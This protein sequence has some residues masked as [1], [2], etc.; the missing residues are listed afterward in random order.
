[1][2]YF[3]LFI[4]I[5]LA[6]CEK[7]N[8]TYFDQSP[9]LQ[10]ALADFEIMDGFNIEIVAAEPLISDPVAMEIDENGD[11]WVAE[12]PGYPLDLTKTGKIKKLI[13]TD[14]DGLPDKSEVFADSLTLP[15]GLMKWEDGLLVADAP[16]VTF[17]ADKDNDGKADVK[18]A[19]LT[20]FSLSNPQ[21]N[22]NTPKF[23]IDNWIYVAHSGAINSFAYEHVFSD[24]GSEIRFP[25]EPNSPKL[26][27][28]ADGRNVRFKPKS[29]ELETLSGESQYGHTTDEWG[30][31]FYTDNANHLF[32]EVMDA[33]YV[34]ANPNLAIEEAME[35][36]SDHG[37]A[38]KVFPITQNPNHQLLTDVGQ[39]TSSCGITW[40]DGGAFGSNFENTTLVGEP[41]HNL[42]HID[43]IET[44]GATFS[45][46]RVLENK[47]FLASKDP[48]FRPVFFYVG[49]DG[50]LYVVDYYRQIVEH[51]EWMS[52]EVNESGALYE[53]TK[54][55]RIYRITPKDGLK[56]DW[57]SALNLGEN[58]TEEL[59]KLLS[60]KNGWYR[61]TAQRLLFQRG[62]HTAA[63]FLHKIINEENEKAKIPALW[64]LHD[65][66]E[67]TS[68]D[69]ES[70]LAAKESGVRENALQL[71]DRV[72][73]NPDFQTE[74]LKAAILKTANDP[75]ER[76]RFQWLCSSAFF[77]F[78]EVKELKS[79]ILKNDVEDKWVGIAAIASSAGSEEILFQNA[80]RDFGTKPS[81]NKS[82]FFAHLAAT[83][84]KKDGANLIT[85][86]LDAKGDNNSWWQAA[87]LSG[88][89]SMQAY[90]SPKTLKNLEQELLLSTFLASQ[91]QELRK[92]I[93]RTFDVSKVSNTLNTA[94][95]YVK[96]KENSNIDFQID[97]MS[98][99]STLGEPKIKAK[100]LENILTGEN[101]KLQL[102]SIK[103]LSNTLSSPE[104]A[105][106]N[107]KYADLT[108]SSKK[109]W[110]AYLLNN[111]NKVSELIK[112]V[113]LGN[114]A[115]ADIEWP[116]IV[117]LMNYYDTNI[118]DYAREVF[119]IN[120]DR[121]AV[122]QNYLPAADMKGNAEN[123]KK[124]FTQN[125]A[126]CHQIDG[127]DGTAFG[128]DLATLKSRNK[129]SI[130][131]EIINPNNSIADKYGQWN[132]ETNDGN[133]LTGIIVSESENSLSLKTLGGQT[134]NIAKASIKSRQIAKQSAM[135][136][137]LEGAISQE[138][139][140]D[141]L[142]LIKGE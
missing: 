54:K 13:D 103:A 48:W 14:G 88:I 91:N 78:P 7:P 45:G 8:A 20:G 140:S 47:E 83:I 134:E 105:S 57:M 128:P 59:T 39:I 73:S 129:H 9:E 55:G 63:T 37:N 34:N 120:E 81:S 97:G 35:K 124:L 100:I 130:I 5:I 29:L 3:S 108:S 138:G 18:K 36:F 30:H 24:K 15:M 126:I 117:E 122:L 113:E 71:A 123:G 61:R 6:S 119:A 121:K 110:I 79:T 27:R 4:L 25:N 2:K 67:L 142:A 49:P 109:A 23:G 112:Q 80:V 84:S 118:R 50:A 10:K 125:C 46:K 74:E 69:L 93:I 65:W 104:L 53:G 51:P 101:E 139:M 94:S 75:S 102:A 12:M 68:D 16:D 107:K 87:M 106:I 72:W 82:E 11:W 116:Q 70:A 114:I 1:M 86:I 135:P 85:K 92:S 32:H 98:L 131:T 56:M 76:V 28:N 90:S 133:H 66:Q 22:M 21:H 31:R 141:I 42:V 132:I 99:L 115:K 58:S 19:M 60:H 44:D 41:V 96:M 64:L 127:K 33:R 77:D 17:L 52:D 43:H 136:N 26:A 40:Y 62:D 111:E 89:S 95:I 38:A 137:G